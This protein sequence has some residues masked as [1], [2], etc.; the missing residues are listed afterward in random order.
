MTTPFPE[1]NGWPYTTG[2]VGSDYNQV[3]RFPEW[4]Q[5]LAAKLYAALAAGPPVGGSPITDT[6]WVDIDILGSYTAIS[7]AE[8]PQVRRIGSVCY[9]R[10]G[11]SDDAMVASANNDVGQLPAGFAPINNAPQRI[12][13]Q[14]ATQ[15]GILFIVN[16]GLV[17]LRT[18]STLSPYYIASAVWVVD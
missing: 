3:N 12:A 11:W 5:L 16:S 7:T 10:G 2:D 9:C 18:N 4:T 8:R 17:Q 6:G 15:D 13:T 1:N 14:N